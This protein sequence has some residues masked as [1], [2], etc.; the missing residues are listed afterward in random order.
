MVI[1]FRE[2]AVEET[3]YADSVMELRAAEIPDH[4]NEIFV[5]GYYGLG[6]IGGGTLLVDRTDTDS[7]DDNGSVLVSGNQIRCKRQF[8]NIVSV[9]DFG[10]KPD[11]LTDASS[12]FQSAIDYVKSSKGLAVFIPDGAYLITTT[13][14]LT[15]SGVAAGLET[16]YYGVKI[17]G[18]NYRHCR[19]IANTTGQPV[20]DLTGSTRGELSN[21]QIEHSADDTSNP[22]VGILLSR[23][24]NNEY[25]G[26]HRIEN[27]GIF[28]YFN[29]AQ[30]YCISSEVNVFKGLRLDNFRD[31]SYGLA[32]H[33]QNVANVTSPYVAGLD[34][35]TFTGGN[36]RNSFYDLEILS[37]GQNS[38][39]LSIEEADTTLI[40]NSYTKVSQAG[41]VGVEFMRTVNNLDVL[42]TRDESDAGTSWLLRNGCTLSCYLTG[43]LRAGLIGEDNTNL[44][45]S[46]ILLGEILTAG[47]L[48]VDLYDAK[49]SNIKGYTSDVRIR[50]SAN[51]INLL[52]P[53]LETSLDIPHGS[54][55]VQVLY[56]YLGGLSSY[57]TNQFGNSSFDRLLLPRTTVTGLSAKR[58]YPD[59]T[60]SPLVADLND[61]SIIILNLQNGLSINNFLNDSPLTGEIPPRVTMIFIQNSAGGHGVSLNAVFFETFGA[62]VDT[63]ANAITVMEFEKI[64]FK[65]DG[66][67]V[68]W[69]KVN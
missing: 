24:L 32:L 52:S 2:R 22:S 4:V 6:T 56:R 20:F 54:V 34:T 51:N 59:T 23:N 45:N 17:I 43:R 39:C 66:A 25:G 64:D 48:S 65:N 40:L 42:N 9:A 58:Q 15:Y 1:A 60:A 16:G 57:N 55:G 37:L 12:A 35:H 29:T 21:F 61:G 63:A 27:I 3:Y 26:G 50:N 67:T 8:D 69:I 33:E 10:A 28:G 11:G 49:D 41:S 30:I 47:S 18:E 38:F 14:D 62:T 19:V 36:T 46:N 13:L 68:K 5:R 53:I 31:N 44:A 7:L